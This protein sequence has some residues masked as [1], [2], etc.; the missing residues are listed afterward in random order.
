MTT[1]PRISALIFGLSLVAGCSRTSPDTAPP[2]SREARDARENDNPSP[3]PTVTSNAALHSPTATGVHID[4][5]LAT[6]C[7][8]STDDDFFVYDA[9]TAD[10]RADRVLEAVSQCVKDGP[11][12]GRRLE[13]VTY[14][15]EAADAKPKAY[16]RTDGLRGALLRGGM[17][18]GDLLMAAETGDAEM[19]QGAV[20]WPNERRVDIRIAPRRSH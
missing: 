14:A 10:V 8:L 6:V 18:E 3:T 2:D 5:T 1:K 13:L 11:L 17:A 4:A 15:T 9:E 7:E 19:P 20:G 16:D 12:S